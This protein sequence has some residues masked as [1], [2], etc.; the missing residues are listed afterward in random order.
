M[1]IK[2]IIRGTKKNSA[3]RSD[4]NQ[5]VKINELQTIV[6][7]PVVE[8]PF[9]QNQESNQLYIQKSIPKTSGKKETK[10]VKGSNKGM[11]G[12]LVNVFFAIFYGIGRLILLSIGVAA[13]TGIIFLPFAISGKYLEPHMIFWIATAWTIMLSRKNY[14]GKAISYS[15]TVLFSTVCLLLA[16]PYAQIFPTLWHNEVY[17]LGVWGVGAAGIASMCHWIKYRKGSVTTE[18]AEVREQIAQT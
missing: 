8:I 14:K 17:L 7:V 13:I 15:L 11:V 10:L 4:D 16:Y 2:R 6:A 18:S 5:K 3:S 9:E 1:L 12:K